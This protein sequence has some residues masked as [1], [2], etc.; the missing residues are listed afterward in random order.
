MDLATL[1]QMAAELNGTQTAQAQQMSDLLMQASTAAQGSSQVLMQ[2][3]QDAASATRTKL[4]GELQTQQ[5]NLKAAQAFGTDIGAQTDVLTPLAEVMRQTS[6]EYLEAASYAAEVEAGSDLFGNPIGWLKDLVV[7]DGVRA[8]RDALEAKMASQAKIAQT[9]NAATQQTIQ[10]QNAIT[11][12]L[13]ADSIEKL[14]RAEAAKYT[15]QANNA[16]IE[17]ARLGA[18]SIEILS[19][20]AESNFSRSA[21]M[22]N[23]Q[24]QAEQMALAR[25]ERAERLKDKQ[26]ASQEA[27]I[28]AAHV[29][30]YNEAVGDPFRVDETTVKRYWGTNTEMGKK[31]MEGDVGGMRMLQTGNL[32]GLVGSTPA[33][34]YQMVSNPE[35]AYPQQWAPAKKVLD[36]TYMD[37]NTWADTKD[38]M[39]QKTPRESM[40]PEELQAK[41]NS[42]VQEK[43]MQK[44]ARIVHGE[45]NPMEMAPLSVIVNAGAT[46]PIAAGVANSKFRTAVIDKFAALGVDQPSMEQYL[47]FTAD[48]IAKGELT[49]TEAAKYGVDA[50]RAGVNLKA[51]T[52]GFK[53]LNVPFQ[54]SYNVPISFLTEIGADA[55][56]RQGFGRAAGAFLGSQAGGLST[57]APLFS[58]EQESLRTRGT[59]VLNLAKHEDFQVALQI[60]MAKRQSK[61]IQDILRSG[62]Q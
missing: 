40:K 3:G 46:D 57:A 41:F 21:Q 8:R 59:K 35:R 18:N 49:S 27:S 48:A 24:Q 51:A 4:L 54:A 16:F 60:M 10:T 5:D 56:G 14:S 6:Q 29:N 20:T 19:R 11:Q 36:E 13:N 53:E 38:P 26:A 47:A 7:G 23:M 2:A 45:G 44:S 50:I 12:T 32:Q 43:A 42:M 52:G 39:T 33:E 25:A 55:A 37:W 30:A 31:L 61:Q 17:A 58:K 62:Q 1:M 34:S 28:I 15:V 22:F 9:L